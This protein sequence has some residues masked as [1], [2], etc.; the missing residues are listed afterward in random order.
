V[1][2]DAHAC[3]P[4]ELSELHRVRS[5]ASLRRA[6]PSPGVRFPF[7][8]VDLRDAGRSGWPTSF[9]KPSTS[10]SHVLSLSETSSSESRI[11]CPS[12]GYL[13]RW[14]PAISFRRRLAALMGFSASLTPLLTTSQGSGAHRPRHLQ[15]LNT[16]LAACS[17]SS[18]P[19][20]GESVSEV[21]LQRFP[22]LPIGS[23][24]PRSYPPAV[25]R[26]VMKQTGLD[27]RVLLPARVRGSRS[28]S[29][30]LLGFHPPGLPAVTP[31]ASPFGTAHP[32]RA[33]STPL[34]SEKHRPHPG[35]SLRLGSL[36][37]R[38]VAFPPELLDLVLFSDS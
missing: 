6:E 4:P 32:L 22:P 15:G 21:F 19:P 3:A 30:P 25:S 7:R 18:Y 17:S 28:S 36:S 11:R 14:S 38:E 23:S 16:L 13:L 1:I 2:D 29:N 20:E 31:V 5:D 27:F 9:R 12:R 35:V 10:I 37:S 33:F 26:N 34:H 8:D 24:S